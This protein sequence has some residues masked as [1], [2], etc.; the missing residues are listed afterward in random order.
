[1]SLLDAIVLGLM[2]GIAE[3]LPISSTGHLILAREVLGLQSEFGLAVDATLHFATALAVILYFRN[4]LMRLAHDTLSWL[5]GQNIERASKAMIVALIVGTIPAVVAGLLLEGYMDTVFR[6]ATLVAWVLIAGSLLFLIAEYVLTRYEAPRELTWKRGLVIGCFQALAL[7]PGMSRSGATIS[8]GMLM[9]LSRES[10]ARFAF[11]LSV[12]II[13]GAGG[14]KLFELG[15]AGVASSEWLMI[16]VAALTAF[17]AGILSIHYLLKFLKN[18]SLAVFV[19]YR[20]ALA[21]V[22]LALT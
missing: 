21:L 5:G 16:G 20:V 4:D 2:Q 6:S 19:V 11:L 1:M 8:G 12:P 17:V 13:L 10:A 3:F 18:H 15:E 7:I 14:K 9:G 22:V